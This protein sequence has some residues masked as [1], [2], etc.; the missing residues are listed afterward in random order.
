MTE[1]HAILLFALGR[2]A[3]AD[4]MRHVE[5]AR[6]QWYVLPETERQRYRSGAKN[7]GL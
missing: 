1:E 4:A 3:E 5:A 2:G 7:L 6:S